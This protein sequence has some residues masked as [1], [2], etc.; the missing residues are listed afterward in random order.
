MGG[1][2]FLA[3]T[4]GEVG[5]HV[6]RGAIEGTLAG[7]DF[8][9]PV[10][11]CA[12]RIGSGSL[13]FEQKGGAI[14][15]LGDWSVDA[16][17]PDSCGD[18]VVAG[19]Q[20]RCEVKEFVPPMGQIATGRTVAD[21]LSIDIKNEAVIGADPHLVGGRDRCEVEGAPEVED[22]RLAQGSG[23]VGNPGGMPLAL[24]RVGLGR[25]L[26]RSKEGAAGKNG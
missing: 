1:V 12:D 18:G 26:R 24:R 16:E 6:D 4:G 13:G 2:D 10:L 3:G 20:I 17:V 9:L 22:N 7:L 21:A 11:G 8:D 19:L 5:Q 15:H 14:A 25:A 23:G